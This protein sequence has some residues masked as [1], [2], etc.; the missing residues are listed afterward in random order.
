MSNIPNDPRFPRVQ[1]LNRRDPSDMPQRLPGTPTLIPAASP[2]RPSGLAPIAPS[3]LGSLP[4]ATGQVVID[5]HHY[6]NVTD[7]SVPLNANQSV[8]ILQQPPGRRNYLMLRNA[9]TG[10][11]NIFISYG[12]NAS[13][14]ATLRLEPDQMALYDNVVPQNDMYA[15]ADDVDAILAFSYSNINA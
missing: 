2:I 13:A 9:G 3:S 14:L 6:A 4:T 7:L 15:F 1:L 5:L 8:L 12:V 11:A 10:T